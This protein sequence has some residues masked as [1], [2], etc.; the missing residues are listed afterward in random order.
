MYTLFQ[1]AVLIY[2]IQLAFLGFQFFEG[3]LTTKAELK[4]YLHP[5]YPYIFAFEFVKNQY[6]KLK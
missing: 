3:N 1:L 2:V 5:K 6:N 4:Q